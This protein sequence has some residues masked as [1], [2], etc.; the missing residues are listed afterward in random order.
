MAYIMTITVANIATAFNTR[1]LIAIGNQ[2]KS[3][4]ALSVAARVVPAELVALVAV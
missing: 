3:V 4:V 2:K 1:E